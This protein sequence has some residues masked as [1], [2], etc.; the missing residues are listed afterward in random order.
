MSAIA[1]TSVDVGESPMRLHWCRP[2]TPGMHPGA[3]VL[4]H[5]GGLDAFTDHVLTTLAGAG[6]V[7]V[8]PDCYHRRPP[9]EDVLI[10]IKTLRDSQLRADMDAAAAL[11]RADSDVDRTRMAVVGHCLGGRSAYLAL[12]TNAG[13]RA[14]VILYNG[15]LFAIRDDAMPAP[16]DFTENIACPIAGFFGELDTNPS[17][18]MVAR[19]DGALAEH[20]IAH[21]FHSYPGAGHAF[22][23]FTDPSHY[24]EA[25][26]SDA[27]MK[28]LAF[29]ERELRA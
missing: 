7:A 2:E 13:F 16:I 17:T 9:G 27:W 5:R 10:S 20:G 6:L 23:D 24:A 19:L 1:E 8:A 26:A 21:E 18:E 29:L 3:L 22:Q 11:L 25:A 14:G 12:G 4:H 28:L 15:D